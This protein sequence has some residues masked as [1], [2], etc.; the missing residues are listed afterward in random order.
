MC[1][2][3]CV[4]LIIS[5]QPVMFHSYRSCQRWYVTLLICHLTK[6]NH[7]F[8]E[9]CESTAGFLSPQ[10]INLSCLAVIALPK[11][12]ILSFQLVMWLHLITW[13]S[14]HLTVW[15]SFSHHNSPGDILFL[16]CQVTSRDHVVIESCDNTG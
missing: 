8:R 3:G 13:S 4:H 12:E 14:S 2:H 6:H 16:I 1:L 5:H 11:E 15:M 9:S 10:V 7:F